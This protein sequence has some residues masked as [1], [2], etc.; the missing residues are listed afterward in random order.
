MFVFTQIENSHSEWSVYLDKIFS[1]I[2][3]DGNGFISLDE[4]IEYIPP[5]NSSQTLSEEEIEAQA[6]MM[7][8]EA[9]TNRDGQISKEEFQQLMRNTVVPDALEQYDSRIPNVAN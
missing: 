6:R 9:D 8:R 7:L 2:D 3:L 1:T 5:N 4:L